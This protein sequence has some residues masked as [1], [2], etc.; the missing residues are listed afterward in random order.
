MH[1]KVPIKP[2][3]MPELPDPANKKLLPDEN[4]W[5]YEE[6]DRLKHKIAETVEPLKQ[7]IETFKGFKDE[8]TLD[9]DALIKELDDPENPPDHFQLQKDVLFHRKE[10]KRL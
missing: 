9:P 10:V 1:L 4:T 2:M 3:W 5:V 8:F 7:Y 6:Y